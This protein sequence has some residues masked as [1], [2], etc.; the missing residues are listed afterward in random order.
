MNINNFV[1]YQLLIFPRHV[2]VQYDVDDMRILNNVYGINQLRT[3]NLICWIT[4][5]IL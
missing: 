4:M 2:S 5:F 3:E 1:E